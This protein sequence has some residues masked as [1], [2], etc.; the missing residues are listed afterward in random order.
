[1]ESRK[2][3]L[4]NLVEKELVDTAREGAEGMNSEKSTDIYMLSCVKQTVGSCY[5]PQGAQP[6]TL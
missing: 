3:V 4:M 1:M 5:I 2:T 6:G